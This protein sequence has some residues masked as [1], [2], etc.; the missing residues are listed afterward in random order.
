MEVAAAEKLAL[1]KGFSNVS[2]LDV[3]T[4]E[5]LDEVRAMCSANTCGQYGKNWAC[6]PACGELEECRARISRFREGILVQ[7]VG[8]IEDSLD[9]EAMMEIEA[10]HKAHFM[11]AAEELRKEFPEL[12]AI[13]AGCCTICAKCAY[14]DGPCRFPDKRVSSLE[15][16]GIVVSELC[17]KNN[18]AYYYGADKIA[19]TSCFLLK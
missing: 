3:S 14:P 5:L 1:E 17:K 12:L 15:A 4:M 18:L 10:E 6:P 16:Y 2:H 8:D 9:F 13:G 7:T 19:Y 11:E